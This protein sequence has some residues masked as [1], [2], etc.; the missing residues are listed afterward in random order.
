MNTATTARTLP[1]V[2]VSDA[3]LVIDTELLRDYGGNGPRYTSYPTA[4]RF[5]EAFDEAAY[6]D[7]LARRDIGGVARP[8][9]FLFNVSLFR[10]PFFFFPCHKNSPR[11]P[12]PPPRPL[13][14]GVRGGG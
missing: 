3:P 6:R 12:A 11:A 14:L 2:S 10:P 13:G 8:P 7:W 1:I 4:D 9:R 5:V